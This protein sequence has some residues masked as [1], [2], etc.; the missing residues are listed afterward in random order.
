MLS[1]VVSHTKIVECWSNFVCEIYNSGH[2]NDSV[3]FAFY[4]GESLTINTEKNP[5]GEV[6]GKPVYL[7]TLTNNNGAQLKVTNYGA[8]VTALL[9]PNKSGDLV[10]VVLGSDNLQDYLDTHTYFGAIVGRYGNRIADGKFTLDGVEYSLVRNNGDN[11]LHGGFKGF[12]QR[13]WQGE[14]VTTGEGASVRLNYLSKDGEE[15]YPGN[16]DVTVTYT[17]TNDNEFIFEIEATTDE[18]TVVNLTNH[19]YYNLNGSKDDA[20]DH[21]LMI[22]ANHFTPI[23]DEWIPLGEIRTVEGTPMDFRTPTKVGERINEDYQ[24]LENGAGYDHN[25]VLNSDGARMALA[26]TVHSPM[27][28]IFMKVYTDMPGVQFYSGNFLDGSYVGKDDITYEK[29]YAICLE[30]QHFP[31]SPNN[32]NF[33]STVLRPGEVYETTTVFE[34]TTK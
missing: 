17:L 25:Y 30:T 9:V 3:V 23:D 33:P 16:L 20:L 27:S 4:G 29:R 5:Y 7:Y 2:N 1:C 31:D 11:H 14:A 21:V 6:N 10:D 28:G 8:R 19:N 22:D 32:P 34:F 26:A 18:P 15:G 24:Q 13:V 12:D